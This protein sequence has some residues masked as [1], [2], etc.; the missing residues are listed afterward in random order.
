MRDSKMLKGFCVT[1]RKSGLENTKA[2][3][4]Q[5]GRQDGR[6]ILRTRG[7]CARIRGIQSRE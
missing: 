1:L 5:N 6:P 7:R 3:E 4:S 2:R